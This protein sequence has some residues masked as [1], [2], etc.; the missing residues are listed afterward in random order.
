MERL[1]GPKLANKIYF[2]QAKQDIIDHTLYFICID[3]FTTL[4]IIQKLKRK[5]CIDK[6]NISLLYATSSIIKLLKFLRKMK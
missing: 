4:I 6:M 1:V 2:A 3:V 5:L